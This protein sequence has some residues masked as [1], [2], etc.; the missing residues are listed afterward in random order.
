MS[1]TS[2]YNSGADSKQFSAFLVASIPTL[3]YLFICTGQ[4]TT[5]TTGAIGQ[6]FGF[7]ASNGALSVFSP[8]VVE[9][10]LVPGTAASNNTV[11]NYSVISGRTFELFAS[12]CGTAVSGN[13]NFATPLSNVTNKANNITATPWVFGDC[14][15]DTLAKSFHVHEFITY[16]RPVTTV[17]RQSIEGYLYWKWMV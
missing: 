12:I 9:G 6:S 5:G 7:Y 14:T 16:S 3:S 2:I 15:G 17:E 10:T 4:L 1:A 8:Y 11:G 13:M